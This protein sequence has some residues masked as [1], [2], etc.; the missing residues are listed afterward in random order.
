M[1]CFE[2]SL[3]HLVFTLPVLL[4]VEPEIKMVF[5]REKRLEMWGKHV[6]LIP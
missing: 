1:E 5:E 6:N 3:R 4:E 2:L